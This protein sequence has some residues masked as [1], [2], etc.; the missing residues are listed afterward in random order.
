MSKTATPTASETSL[1]E[2]SPPGATRVGASEDERWMAEAIREGDLA[3]DAGDVPVGAVVIDA[4]GALIGRGRNEREA[5]QDPTAHA[6]VYALRSAAAA[7]GHWR[8]EGATVYVTLEPCPMCAGALVN[9]RVARVVYG[10][11]DPKAGAVETLFSIGQDARLNHRFE[12]RGGVLG[13]ACATQLKDFFVTL[14][15]RMAR[16]RAESSGG[17]R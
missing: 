3:A 7:V 13:E 5:R 14:R 6:E 15:A 4:A 17:S 2:A 1:E 8:L 16:R 9:A 10:C 11:A 12:V